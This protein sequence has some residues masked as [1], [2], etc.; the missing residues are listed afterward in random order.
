MKS[1]IASAALAL[2]AGALVSPAGANAFRPQLE[3]LMAQ[4]VQPWLADAVVI[5]AIKAANDR[6]A[7][8]TKAE[9]EALD[10][11]WRKEAEAG[12]G[13]LLDKVLGSDLSAY[14]SERKAEMDG[15]VSELFV[16]DNRGLT[17]GLSDVTTD[18]WQGDEDKW[19]KTFLAGP[20]AV[21]VDEV[22]FDDSA[23][24]FLSQISR[25]IV[26]PATGDAI[27]AIT[28]GVNVELF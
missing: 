3:A 26:D 2:A 15:T 25:T 9:I 5:D 18:Y 20:G 27:G 4:E 13:P 7:T 16:M 17:V 22:G 28:V 10:Q 14:L 1:L 11:Q 23:E 19:Q 21:F 24:S 12:S 6:H 8:L